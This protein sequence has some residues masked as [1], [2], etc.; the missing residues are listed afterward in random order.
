MFL[1]CRKTRHA[2]HQNPNV[3]SSSS[4]SSARGRLS[5]CS[6]YFQSSQHVDLLPHLNQ[7]I[8][9]TAA[10]V[11]CR[12]TGLSSSTLSFLG[13]DSTPPPVS[14]MSPV[15][16]KFEGIPQQQR[17]QRREP[18]AAS[19]CSTMSL[20]NVLFS[21]HYFKQHKVHTWSKG[22]SQTTSERYRPRP[23]SVE[24]VNLRDYSQFLPLSSSVALRKID[25]IHH[26]S[27]DKSSLPPEVFQKSPPADPQKA[28]L[29]E[30]P[31]LGDLPPKP[32][33]S[34]LPPKPGELPPKPQLS[35]LPPKP[36]LGDLPPKPQLKDLPPKPH[37]ADIPPKPG[38]TEPSPRPPPGEPTTPRPQTQ[39]PPP[40]HQQPQ[41][42]P[43]PNQQA[44]VGIPP[45][46]AAEDANGT[47]PGTT[48]MPV[49][50]PRKI[51]TVSSETGHTPNLIVIND[52]LHHQSNTRSCELTVCSVYLFLS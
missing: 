2:F 30:R 4:P 21:Q 1:R 32:Q 3:L 11:W 8:C 35:D 37:L 19:E 14:K 33:A 34:D 9:R 50:L 20:F 29:A 41:D 18:P 43:S 10:V 36:Q 47:S 24:S 52:D 15:S 27:V 45:Q 51:N 38:P 5:H 6:V 31:Q 40:P 13:S 46:Q 16:N 28:P 39:P 49:P 7:F 48:E 44:N 17:Y 12:V 26:P 25:T 23:V 42:S 22:S